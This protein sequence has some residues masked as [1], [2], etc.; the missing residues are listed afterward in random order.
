MSYTKRIAIIYQACIRVRLHGHAT[1]ISINLRCVFLLLQ[2][3]VTSS[4][5][6]FGQ[7]IEGA[8]VEPARRSNHYVG[9]AID[10]NLSAPGYW[11]NSKCLRYELDQ[12]P[13]AKCFIEKIRSDPNLRW[14][15]DFSEKDEVHIDDGISLREPATYDMLYYQLQ[16]NC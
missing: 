7:P 4:F 5:R 16:D 8:I 2:V 13:E 12:R 14:G 1:L 9:H 11:C 3:Y 15:G 10:M 6:K